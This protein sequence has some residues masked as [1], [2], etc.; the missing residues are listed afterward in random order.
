M[1]PR[2]RS[3]V[4]D[5]AALRLHRDGTRVLNSDTNVA[6]RRAKHAVRDARGNWI[7][8]DAGG[9]GSVKQ[10][11]SAPHDGPD[12]VEED[13]EALD[14]VSLPP[15]NG[16][17]KRRAREDK[18]SDAEDALNPRARKRRRFDKDLSYLASRSSSAAR[19][20]ANSEGTPP[21]SVELPG[22]LPVPSSDLLKCLHYF[23]STYYTA[24]GQ[25]YDATREVRKQRRARQLEKAKTTAKVT[26]ANRAQSEGTSAYEPPH[27]PGDNQI[28]P[29]DEELEDAKEENSID[30]QDTQ[31]QAEKRVRKKRG[32]KQWRPMEK[33]MYRIFDGSALMAIGAF[34]GSR[35]SSCA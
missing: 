16:K 10:R 5:L 33:D 19:Q 22:E 35:M 12:G 11:R 7:A 29:S 4:H 25:L 21:Q 17:G 23:A 34:P 24:M 20:P 31:S 1:N 8:R 14:D 32:R 26:R 27:T 9:L 15:E 3:T 2:R 13:E 28:K 30:E 18:D 6:S